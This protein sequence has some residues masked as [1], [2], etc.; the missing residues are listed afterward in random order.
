MD[1]STTDHSQIRPSPKVNYIPPSLPPVSTLNQQQQPQQQ[2]FITPEQP[3]NVQYPPTVYNSSDGDVSTANFNAQQQQQMAAMMQ[4]HQPWAAGGGYPSPYMMPYPAPMMMMPSQAGS[5]RPGSR[6]SSRPPSRQNATAPVS[7]SRS[8]VNGQ[9]GGQTPAISGQGMLPMQGYPGYMPPGMYNPWFD[10]YWQSLYASYQNPYNFGYSDEMMKYWKQMS[11]TDDDK[12]SHHSAAHSQSKQSQH[13]SSMHTWGSVDSLNDPYYQTQNAYIN[14]YY[15]PNKPPVSNQ[16]K[17]QTKTTTDPNALLTTAPISNQQIT[18]VESKTKTISARENDE[19]EEEEDDEDED[20][21]DEDENEDSDDT[22]SDRFSIKSDLAQVDEE[23]SK[24]RRTPLLYIRPH[25]RAKFVF[26]QLIQVLPQ[27]PSDTN[28]PATV[29][30]I[31]AN[32]LHSMAPSLV[33][34]RQLMSDFIGPLTASTAKSNVIRYCERQSQLA[35]KSIHIIDRDALS[36]IW[37]Y[38][39]LL[40][41][42]N[43]V[44]DVRVDIPKILW[45]SS[46][47]P[48]I[49]E[50]SSNS[51][52]T[53][54]SSTTLENS[55]REFLA[56][57][58]IDTS[59][60][61]ACENQFYTH[62]LII[63]YLTDKQLFEKTIHNIIANLDNG[64]VLKTFYELG[65]GSTPSV[66]S[67]VTKAHYGDWKRH[68]AV[69]LAN[70]TDTNAEFVDLCI[71]TM[72]DTFITSGRI[73]AGHFCYLIAN[74]PFG[75]YRNNADKLAVIG[76]IHAGQSNLSFATITNLQLT[77]VYEYSLRKCLTTFIPLKIYYTSKLVLHGLK[78]EALAY[79][80]EI[81]QTLI[82]Q[83][84]TSYVQLVDLQ[85]FILI[86]EKSRAFNRNFQLDPTSYKEPTWLIELKSIIQNLIEN[87]FLNKTVRDDSFNS[88]S[89]QPINREE[90]TLQQQQQQQQQ[91]NLATYKK[92]SNI[93]RKTEPIKTTVPLAS[94]TYPPVTN[95]NSSN[96]YDLSN[97]VTTEQIPY[98]QPA[99][100][101][102]QNTLSVDTNVHYPSQIQ[103]NYYQPP[104]QQQSYPSDYQQTEINNYSQQWSQQQQQ[105][106]AIPTQPDILNSSTQLPST[107]NSYYQPP[108][109]QTQYIQP[110]FT[111]TPNSYSSQQQWYPSGQIEQRERLPSNEQQQLGSVSRRSSVI[112]FNQIDNISPSN[113]QQQS[114]IDNRK[115]SSTSTQSNTSNQSSKNNSDTANFLYQS[116]QLKRYS[117]NQTSSITEESQQQQQINGPVKKKHAIF[118]DS[119]DVFPN[120]Q[121][122]SSD[123]K[124]K[125][126]SATTNQTGASGPKTGLVGSLFNRL[127]WKRPTQAHLPDDKDRTLKFD[128]QTGRWI[129]TSKSADEQASTQ[130]KPPPMMSSN[131]TSS[132][133]VAN[134]LQQQQEQQLQ[135]QQQ[136]QQSSSSTYNP[137][138]TSGPSHSSQPRT[139]SFGAGSTTTTTSTPAPQTTA[140]AW[141]PQS[142]TVTA[143]ITA[144]PSQQQQ[145][146]QQQQQ[147]P[148]AQ[149]SAAQQRLQALRQQQQQQQ[150]QQQTAMQQTQAPPAT[151]S[152]Q[153]SLKSRPNQSR[154]VDI[155]ASTKGAIAPTPNVSL[156]DLIPTP[157][158]GMPTIASSNQTNNYFVPHPSQSTTDGHEQSSFSS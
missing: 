72:G 69:M 51:N 16:S 133:F 153:Y 101:N 70:R 136:P 46:N 117:T 122:K 86:A 98:S 124:N 4:M 64:D 73:Y 15:P 96:G 63:S 116:P 119:D 45:S 20:E 125:T 26:D 135:Q 132:S 104:S 88:S 151:S 139:L 25:L 83:G 141:P 77:E 97:Q 94:V 79:C 59:I 8:L 2:T 106:Q 142:N 155:L 140:A 137:S 87:A 143:P 56:L 121:Q 37:Q 111:S 24:A 128:Q 40:I 31:S 34:E 28:Q 80:E 107:N 115:A 149:L 60:K 138:M 53:S 21:E 144:Q 14:G 54:L 48:I 22:S 157:S 109:D 61:F 10:P 145:Q 67:N 49:E 114:T 32:S 120:N 58:E 131:N 35:N 84:N 113:R 18:S 13:S 129:D 154:Y 130:V 105:Q 108:M 38:M 29:E 71:K 127:G 112:T 6:Q 103:S 39:A 36:I 76:S 1:Q 9:T 110:G 118:D 148:P 126:P 95:T 150:Q 74:V 65:A 158:T 57:G 44:I 75:S 55:L 42:N 82:R 41:K 85:L 134:P 66:V 102:Y 23:F 93:R 100:T 47:T 152:N 62:A 7:S 11:Q 146:Q 33:E 91:T 89:I 99:P 68:L 43:G 30:I 12:Y 92:I 3:S 78:R 17:R 90:N 52:N 50:P 147:K 156:N 27:S 123:N 5:D 19:N 81:G